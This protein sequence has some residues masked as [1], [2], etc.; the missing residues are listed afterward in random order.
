MLALR[1]PEQVCTSVVI[2]GGQQ[3]GLLRKSVRLE[4]LHYLKKS[5]KQIKYA[6]IA[7]GMQ[8][9]QEP[10]C[11][12]DVTTRTSQVLCSYIIMQ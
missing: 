1:K 11:E 6:I 7:T 3:R 5:F 10:H 4:L 9:C 8:T 12:R 2:E